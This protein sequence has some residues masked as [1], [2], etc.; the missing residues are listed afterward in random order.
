MRLV[1][2]AA[3]IALAGA[4]VAGAL[5]RDAGAQDRRPPSA[6]SRTR[7]ADLKRQ[8]DAAMDALRYAEALS[9]YQE[10]Y[11]LSREPALL[12]NKGRALQALDRYPE[13]LAELERFSKEAPTELRAR[14]PRLDELIAEV[15]GRV[16]T[17]SIV[18]E[19]SG[20]RVLVRDKHVGMTP[21]GGPLKLTSGDA[22]VEV[23]AEGYE[24]FRR[25]LK[26]PGGGSLQIVA[27]LQSKEN[28]GTLL[29][30]SPTEGARVAVDG[31]PVGQV[32]AEALLPAGSHTV[33]V[34]RDGFEDSET[35]VV[36]QPGGRREIEVTLSSGGPITSKWWFW[37]GVGVVV[38]GGVAVTWALLTERSPDQGDIAPGRVSAPIIRF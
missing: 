6:A 35:S 2:L 9:A 1:R 21:L 3:V 24:P 15:R 4:A 37:T 16:A 14:V 32:P 13:A 26:L 27:Q 34:S 8:G 5:P 31:K 12:Y 17:V 28:T 18:C 7:A 19:V 29:V 10:A 23:S 22:V 30:R 33:L 11:A 25:R 38:A 36:I 20:A